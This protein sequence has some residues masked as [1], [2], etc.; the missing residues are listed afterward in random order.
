MRKWY[1]EILIGVA[2]ASIPMVIQRALDIYFPVKEEDPE[3][4]E[5]NTTKGLDTG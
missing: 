4:D 1:V 5:E 3:K 2:V